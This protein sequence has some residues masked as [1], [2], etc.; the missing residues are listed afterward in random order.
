MHTIKRQGRQVSLRVSIEPY[1]VTLLQFHSLQGLLDRL[2]YL[3][4]RFFP[5]MTH[6]ANYRSKVSAC[7]SLVWAVDRP[8]VESGSVCHLR[9]LVLLILAVWAVWLTHLYTRSNDLK[10]LPECHRC[11]SCLH[12]MLSWNILVWSVIVYRLANCEAFCS[13]NLNCGWLLYTSRPHG[14][15]TSV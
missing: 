9:T 12:Q 5:S 6:F 3:S 4:H 14:P 1:H 13:T 2:C 7:E 10:D 15:S 11:L 8:C